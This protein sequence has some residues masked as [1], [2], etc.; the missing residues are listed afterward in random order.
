MKKFIYILF[1]MILVVSFTAK[2]HPG[3]IN[4]DGNDDES[5]EELQ[6]TIDEYKKK[7]MLIRIFVN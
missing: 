3:T 5:C 6:S 4:V 2:A 7:L 1:V